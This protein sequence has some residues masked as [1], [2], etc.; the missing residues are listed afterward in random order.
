MPVSTDVS[1]SQVFGVSHF[2]FHDNT[3]DHCYDQYYYSTVRTIIEGRMEGIK[4]KRKNENGVIGL[5]D[6]GRLQQD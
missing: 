2:L 3:S 4:Y 1:H 6:E 5:D